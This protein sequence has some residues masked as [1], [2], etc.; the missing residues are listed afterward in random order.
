MIRLLLTFC[1]G[2]LLGYE[3]GYDH[4]AKHW[5]VLSDPQNYPATRR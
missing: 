2:L 4:A 1:L 5:N 3:A